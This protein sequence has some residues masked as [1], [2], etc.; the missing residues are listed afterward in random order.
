MKTVITLLMILFLAM[1]GIAL[2]QSA[3]E[4]LKADPEIAKLS[5]SDEE[6]DKLLKKVAEARSRAVKRDDEARA[7]NIIDELLKDDIALDS[8][9]MSERA[10]EIPIEKAAA[11]ALEKAAAKAALSE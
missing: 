1:P 2:S 7:R 10:A 8:Q 6:L 11:K 9:L 3:R 5:L 4:Q